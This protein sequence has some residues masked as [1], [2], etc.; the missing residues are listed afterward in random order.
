MTDEHC[1]LIISLY[2]YWM[3]LPSNW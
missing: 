1:I 3:Q 2:T